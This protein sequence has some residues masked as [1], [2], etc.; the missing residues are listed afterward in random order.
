MI[1]QNLP[2]RIR[3]TEL[4]A[5]SFYDLYWDITEHKHTHYKL[6]G[7]RGSTKTSFIRI[8]IE[9]GNIY[10]QQANAMELPKLGR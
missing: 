8:I 3:L 2:I 7:G 1:S 6:A 5:P 10:N 4:I 9:H